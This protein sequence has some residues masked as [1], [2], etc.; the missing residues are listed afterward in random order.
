MKQFR[1]IAVIVLIVVALFAVVAPVSAHPANA[2]QVQ[3]PT[4]PS[5][6]DALALLTTVG[7]LGIV[8][9]FFLEQRTWFQNLSGNAKMWT[10]LAF[11]IGVPLAAKLL[12]D[13]VPADVFVAIDPYWKIIGLGFA[14][15]LST[16]WYHSSGPG[17]KS[18]G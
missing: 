3:E 7:G 11:S 4:I 15:F 9:S 2:P 18:K 1:T 14:F 5:A 10:V 17:A 16:Q 8:L 6:T 13:F 12:L